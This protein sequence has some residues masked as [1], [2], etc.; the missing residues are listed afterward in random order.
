M[1]I[2]LIWQEHRGDMSMLPPL[3]RGKHC[4]HPFRAA[5]SRRG[6]DMKNSWAAD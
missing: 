3:F 1:V 5:F 6:E 4:D 2:C